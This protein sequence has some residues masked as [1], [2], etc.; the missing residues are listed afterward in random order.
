MDAMQF[1]ARQL[2]KLD[3]PTAVF[4]EIAGSSFGAKSKQ[5]YFSQTEFGGI[6]FW[7]YGD[8]RAFIGF[9]LKFWDFVTWC[10]LCTFYR[11]PMDQHPADH[12]ER[13]CHCLA[14]SPI[15]FTGKPFLTCLVR[16]FMVELFAAGFLFRSPS[17]SRSD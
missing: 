2:H 16:P 5:F 11:V 6:S 17:K 15:R 12:S 7:G 3:D 8:M 4:E 9:S 13:W 14:P 10:V 1:R